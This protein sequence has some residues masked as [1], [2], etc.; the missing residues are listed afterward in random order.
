MIFQHKI[1][2]FDEETA[3]IKGKG[4]YHK[5][6]EYVHHSGLS[7]HESAFFRLSTSQAI[8]LF[9]LAS[10]IV[11]SFILSWK[12][13]LIV[14]IAIL[15]VVYFADLLFNLFLII[16]SFSESPEISISEEELATLNEDR[17]PIYTIFCPLYK[18][19]RV[20]PQFIEAMKKL[21][22][23]KEK[24]QIML[25]LEEDDKESIRAAEKANLPFYFDV[26]VIPDSKPKTKPKALNYGL[27]HAKG[28]Y[29]V[30][31]DAEDVPDPKQLKKVLLAFNKS[32]SKVKCIQAKLNFYNPHQNILT[33]VFSAEYSLWFDLVLT[34]LQ[35][36]HAPIPLGG[37]SNH[38][39][40]KDIHDLDGWD[41]FNVTE[42]C[43]LGMRLTKKGYKTAII[44]SVTL[45]EANSS[46]TNWFAQRTR[47]IKGY[48][49]TYLVHMR[50]PH[51]FVTH[52]KEPHVVT[53]QLVVGGKIM[54]MIINPIMWALTI[55]YFVF[56]STIGPTIE[57]FFPTPV[58]YMAIFSLVFGN[59]LYL[60]YYMIGCAKRE[61]YELIKYV[62]LVPVY[63]LMMSVAAYSSWWKLI[64]QPHY[65]SKTRHGLHLADSEIVDVESD[66]DDDSD[67]QNGEREEEQEFEL[68]KLRA[69]KFEQH[70]IVNDKPVHNFTKIAFS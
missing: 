7:H 21:D 2:L 28:E 17:L 44:D 1:E 51:E 49:Q 67:M 64:R 48:I 5:G 15:T 63:W 45:E 35:S 47:W 27:L 40:L 16:R 55:S 37:T 43:D 9:V 68:K 25:L 65:W 20:I 13:S 34:G 50:R 24:L 70:H 19:G 42:D 23:P 3:K 62:F 61:Q 53:F 8:T 31:Y 66:E 30:V 14:I 60:Y 29:V 11:I 69:F 10:L 36:I 54:S 41:A 22:Y 12:I 26:Q 52:W 57:T 39:R 4:F 6:V 38:F 46:V 58:F 18:E 33:R 56:R 32:S 59:F